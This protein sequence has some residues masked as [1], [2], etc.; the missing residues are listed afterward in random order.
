MNK[1]M[2]LSIVV[3]FVMLW[4][5]VELKPEAV[6]ESPPSSVYVSCE[7]CSKGFNATHNW[8]CRYGCNRYYKTKRNGPVSITKPTPG[9]TDPLHT[10]KGSYL[11]CKKCF[12]H[13]KMKH[14]DPRCKYGCGRWMTYPTVSQAATKVK[15]TATESAETDDDNVAN[16][17]SP[18]DENASSMKATVL[19]SI[20]KLFAAK[21]YLKYKHV[22]VLVGLA[23][24]GLAATVGYLVYR[25]KWQ[26][27]RLNEEITSPT[28][29]VMQNL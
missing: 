9:T 27:K 10:R 8:R 13:G 12:G 3:V 22:F 29:V 14:P 11:D 26:R 6:T 19:T 1:M 25:R 7:D 23:I 24:A 15:P 21:V 2:S 28:A 16:T 17:D 5:P 20:D 4:I 18:T